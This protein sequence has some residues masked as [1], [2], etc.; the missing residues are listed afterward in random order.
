MKALIIASLVFF[1]LR[2]MSAEVGEEQKSPCPYA[3]QTNKREAKVVETPAED[4]KQEAAKT[5][6]K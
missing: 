2:A 1:S 6:S 5:I 4:I 3:S